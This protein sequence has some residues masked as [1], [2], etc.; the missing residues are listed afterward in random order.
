MT[1]RSGFEPLTGLGRIGE[2]ATAPAGPGARSTW[3]RWASGIDPPLHCA[4]QHPDV[5]VRLRQR[6]GHIPVGR[7]RRSLR[8]RTDMAAVLEV[9]VGM[10]SAG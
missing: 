6:G 1:A 7:A 2:L 5:P 4:G 9:R 10:G 8:H 3:T